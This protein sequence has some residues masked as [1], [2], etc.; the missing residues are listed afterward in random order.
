MPVLS[1]ACSLPNLVCDILPLGMLH[2]HDAQA[3]KSDQHKNKS[4]ICCGSLAVKS[5]TEH[6][7]IVQAINIKGGKSYKAARH[8]YEESEDAVRL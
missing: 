1:I 6:M 8:F 5:G 2:L 4:A 7:M 3:A